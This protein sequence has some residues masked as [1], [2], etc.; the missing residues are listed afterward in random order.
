M[1]RQGF[2]EQLGQIQL[3][4]IRLSLRDKQVLR[5]LLPPPLEKTWMVQ[6]LP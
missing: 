1:G 3:G 6:F 5:L 2:P 4:H